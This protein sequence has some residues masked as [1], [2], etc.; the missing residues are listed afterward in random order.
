VI[1]GWIALLGYA[2]APLLLLSGRYIEWILMVF[3]R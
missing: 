1:A 2:L 3:P